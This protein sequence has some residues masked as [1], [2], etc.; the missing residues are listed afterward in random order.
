[1]DI[2]NEL[3]RRRAVCEQEITEQ[4]QKIREYERAYESLRQFD[5][6]VNTAQ[7]NFQNVNTDKLI[8][9]LSFHL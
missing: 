3:V 8:T 7:N 2:I 6:A 9:H 5:G 4:N 1:M